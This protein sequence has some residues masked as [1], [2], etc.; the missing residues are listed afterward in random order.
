MNDILSS[1]KGAIICGVVVIIAIGGLMGQKVYKAKE[2]AKVEAIQIAKKDAETKKAQDLYAKQKADAEVKRL[3]GRESNRGTREA[4]QR[5]WKCGD[6]SSR[7]VPRR[8]FT[9]EMHTMVNSIVIASDDVGEE[10]LITKENMSALIKRDQQFET[11]PPTLKRNYLQ[12]LVDGTPVTSSQ[13][14]Y[15][16]NYVWEKLK[17]K[18]GRATDVDISR[19]PSWAIK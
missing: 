19:L 8:Q 9:N 13:A 17:G 12:H 14:A 3:S 7:I 4:K 1:R 2:A 18:H 6:R 10:K 16:H 5:K 11:T 15:D